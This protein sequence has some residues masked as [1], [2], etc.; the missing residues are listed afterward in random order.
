MRQSLFVKCFVTGLMLWILSLPL[1]AQEVLRKVGLERLAPNRY[2]VRYELAPS[3]GRELTRAQVQILRRRGGTIVAIDT[4]DVTPGQLRP[5]V[6][7]LTWNKGG[8][9]QPGDELG[10]RVVVYYRQPDLA[11]RETRDTLNRPPVAHAGAFLE[12]R[13]PVKEPVVLNGSASRDAEGALSRIEWKLVEG[14]SRLQLT[15]PDSLLTQAGGDFREGRYVFELTVTDAAGARA[16]DRMILTVKPPLP[17]PPPADVV[18]A[19]ATPPARRDTAARKSETVATPPAPVRPPVTTQRPPL[20]RQAA[21]RLRGGPANA[22]L[23]L[24]VPGLGHYFVSGDHNGFDRKPAVL[25]ITALYAGSV[26]GAIYYKLRA[27]KQYNQYTELSKF[28]EYQFDPN[29]MIIGV[30]GGSQVQAAQ[31]LK[32]AQ[33]SNRNAMILAGVSAGIITADLIYTLVK[34]LKNKRAW[35]DE[36]GRVRARF[37]LSGD[38]T[39]ITAGLRLNW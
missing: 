5:G 3:E 21:P 33:T 36:H 25:L 4:I 26:G 11:R 23:N 39:A 2:Q 32:D 15:R 28:R 22:L 13:L 29:G 1:G 37:F 35:Q 7:R 8:D 9:V 27:D 19:P 31:Y 17:Q 12:V 24:A 30:R 38:G 6:Q 20:A 10:A 16:T 34:G 18:K 14:P